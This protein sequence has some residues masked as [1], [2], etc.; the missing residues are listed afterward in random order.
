MSPIAIWFRGNFH[1]G[2]LSTA[3]NIRVSESNCG[4]NMFQTSQASLMFD[5]CSRTVDPLRS[6]GS[7]SLYWI[8]LVQTEA[9]KLRSTPLQGARSAVLSRG[10]G[11]RTSDKNI[12][13]AKARFRCRLRVPS[14]ISHIDNR[15]WHGGH[16]SSIMDKIT[17]SPIETN[18]YEICVCPSEDHFSLSSP[19]D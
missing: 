17:S 1:E 9:S 3:P 18:I 11:H 5:L 6:W 8:S 4:E 12:R 13:D 2:K 14:A 7:L 16:H 10:L 15:L 19:T